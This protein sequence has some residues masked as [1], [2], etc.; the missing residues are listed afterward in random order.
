MPE[1]DLST[2]DEMEA[3]IQ[4]RRPEMDQPCRQPDDCRIE[5]DLPSRQ[6]EDGRDE[7]GQQKPACR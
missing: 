3:E 7:M 1:D 5:M 4:D 6:P 2:V